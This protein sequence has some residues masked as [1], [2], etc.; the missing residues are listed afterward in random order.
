MSWKAV[1]AEEGCTPV[2]FG[3]DKAA[4]EAYAHS[5]EIQHWVEASCLAQGVPFK[6]TN[7]AILRTVATLLGANSRRNT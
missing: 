6:V 7:P 2:D 3:A 4:A 5:H 1:C